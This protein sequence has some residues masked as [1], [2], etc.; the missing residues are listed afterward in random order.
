[1]TTMQTK[2][3]SDEAREAYRKLRNQRNQSRAADGVYAL[4]G[5]QIEAVINPSDPL[6]LLNGPVIKAAG[7]KLNIPIWEET[8][9]DPDDTQK[10]ELFIAPGHVDDPADP[11]FVK[12]S[13]IPDLVYPFADTW[14]GD[15]TIALNKL[16]PN[17]PYTFKHEVWLHHGGHETSPLIHVT[18]D[19]TAPYEMTNPPEPPAMTFSTTQLDDS[20]IGSVTG[21]IPDYADKAP[22][23]QF[24]YWYASD[25]LPSD[26]SSLQPVAPPADVPA[27]RN[28]TIPRTYIEGKLD[29]VFYVLYA[30]IDKARN[31]SHLS[32]WT[33][34]VT[35]LGA[36]PSAL[37]K[38]EVPVAA[39]GAV[40]D[41][42]TAAGGVI[43]HIKPYTG[44]KSGDKIVATWGG[45]PLPDTYA[46]E[47]NDT[48]I[49][50]PSQTL[51]TAYLGATGEKLT[52][53]SY[54]V[55]RLGR[56][57]GPQQDDFMVNFEIIG[58]PR[59]DPDPDFP[60]ITNPA[61]LAGTVRGST[62]DNVLVEADADKEVSFEFK[63]HSPVK[64]GETVKFFWEGTPVTE[65]DFTIT[66]ETP[67]LT[68]TVK[69]PWS[70]VA[71]TDN[72]PDK[73]VYYT[74]GDPNVTP[75]R[76]K[77]RI[78]SVNVNDAIVLK[79]DAPTFVGLSSSGWIN[80]DSRQSP[81]GAI[82][83]T[84]P[85]LSKWLNPG[86]K[87]KM[88]WQLFQPRSGTTPVPNTLFE[89]ELTLGDLGDPHP[90]TGFTWRVTPYTQYVSPG[91]NP[92]AH[93]DANAKVTYS[94]MLNGK[95]VTSKTLA[96]PVGM[97][98]GSGPC[99]I[100]PTP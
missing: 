65:A 32:G 21:V 57:F 49:V 38:P 68:K 17:G 89:P 62:V 59:P 97:F 72:G 56:T 1:M 11:S 70:Y 25:P 31:R 13:D 50:V 7:M 82:V 80:C 3:Q 18:S 90:V 2:R 37:V 84:V 22:G 52:P 24:V 93:S 48:E 46:S 58:P 95:T 51:R 69:F 40:I 54:V 87:V 71:A 75:N 30:L 43:V 88:S 15:Y 100:F 27:S 9:T 98:L 5:A 86:D 20:N 29:G 12:V 36:L 64:A 92:P 45:I 63:I 23:D 41:L 99:A 6:G 96:A 83:V 44:W 4:P 8:G 73:K 33:R 42:D 81:D 60:D 74:I 77:S 91:Y 19:I 94:F 85:D 79:P 26:P 10:L 28:V 53:V 47:K 66:T 39:G 16:S 76:Q 61:L 34:F 55:D 14:V 67:G 78:T 35:T